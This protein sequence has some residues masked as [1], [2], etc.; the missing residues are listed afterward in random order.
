MIP[1][2]VIDH[3]KVPDTASVV[4]ATLSFEEAMI[5]KIEDNEIIF[6]G[7]MEEFRNFKYYGS[8]REVFIRIRSPEISFEFETSFILQP[9]IEVTLP[10][11][12]KI[13]E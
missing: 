11:C 5:R 7:T 10:K 13:K 12:R 2:G 9:T 4:L 6:R 1:S 3:Y 8:S